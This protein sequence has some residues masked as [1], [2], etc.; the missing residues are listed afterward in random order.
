MDKLN[1]EMPNMFT[2]HLVRDPGM[3]GN[4]EVSVHKNAD[5]SDAAE[6]CFSKK[7]QGKF[8]FADNATWNEFMERVASYAK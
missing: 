1:A 7:Q 2:F 6:K 3:T 4:F 8:P 5:L